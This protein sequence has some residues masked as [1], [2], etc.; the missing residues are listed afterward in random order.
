MQRLA[1]RPRWIHNHIAR[2]EHGKS[3]TTV[4]KSMPP[5]MNKDKPL[6]PPSKMHPAIDLAD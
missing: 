6:D 3:W 1:L 4:S 2:Y 5:L